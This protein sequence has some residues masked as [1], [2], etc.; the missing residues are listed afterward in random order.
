MDT[1]TRQ[2]SEF[3]S[4]FN[5]WSYSPDAC[6]LHEAS[7]HVKS[8]FWNPTFGVKAWLLS[9]YIQYSHIFI[10]L[11][12]LLKEK[13]RCILG[14]NVGITNLEETLSVQDY[15]IQDLRKSLSVPSDPL[16]EARLESMWKDMEEFIKKGIALS[17]KTIKPLKTKSKALPI[18]T[19][20]KSE[21]KITKNS[22]MTSAVGQ[23]YQQQSIKPDILNPVKELPYYWKIN[24]NKLLKLEKR[25]NT[26]LKSSTFKFL[27]QV[28]KDKN[29]I[30]I[31]L[32]ESQNLSGKLTQN[33]NIYPTI[34][35]YQ[36]NEELT[37]DEKLYSLIVD[38]LY[39]SYNVADYFNP[40]CGSLS[41]K[42]KESLA[43]KEILSETVINEE[44]EKINNTVITLKENN[45][46]QRTGEAEFD[47]GGV[48]KGYA[49][50]LVN[51]YLQENGVGSYLI[52]AGS[53]SIAL[54]EKLTKDGLFTVGLKEVKNAYIKAK[55]CFISTSSIYEQGVTIDGV[56]YSHIINP[57]NGS[58]INNYD[59]VIVISESGSY[60]DAISTSMMSHL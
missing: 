55:H 5:S 28:S 52:N 58:A 51:N 23:D 41:K 30:I 43:K 59:A 8:S 16:K 15:F 39:M 24:Q 36:T 60:G 50:D 49:L 10:Q 32:F 48:A 25:L 6:L 2:T 1:S 40:L 47:L 3:Q 27:R 22:T 44:L 54:G 29:K 14:L 17:N 42:W 46:I 18:F 7:L 33:Y 19:T 37:I 53:S 13:V 9:D 11:E 45:V 35:I 31:N 56:T 38:S 34:R 12:M 4:V 21:A 57:V 20:R 26:M